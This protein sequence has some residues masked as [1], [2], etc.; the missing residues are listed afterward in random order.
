[1]FRTLLQEVPFHLVHIDLSSKPSWYRSINP[2][3]LVPAVAAIDGTIHVES[4]DICRWVDTGIGSSNPAL[5]PSDEAGKER[6]HNIISAGSA[7]VEAGLSFISGTTG[8]YWG[9]GSGQTD[10]QRSEFECALKKAI[11]DPIVA[12][13]GG[14]F[15]MGEQLTLAD[16]A[17][18]PF[19]KRYQVA[20]REF[21]DGYDVSSVLN[22]VVGHWLDAMGQRSA[23]QI[24]TAHDEL[25][26]TAYKNHSSL[27]FFDYD[28]YAATELHPQNEVYKI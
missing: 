5:S 18:Y 23:V 24:T 25:L 7:L 21:C 2:L 22:G 17:V 14:P 15:L 4:L 13:N 3:G 12:S 27:D 26:L 8:R 9:I 11:V 19:V 1:M 16:I 10:S 20:C 28:S 6:M